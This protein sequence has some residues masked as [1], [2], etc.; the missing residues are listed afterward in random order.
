MLVI[1]TDDQLLSPQVI[2]QTCLLADGQ[3]QPRWQQGQLRCG[4]RIRP[5][6]ECGQQPVEYKCCMGFRIA[7]I[8]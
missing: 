4:Q 5:P 8:N 7:Q 6:A 1:V 3:G 2:C